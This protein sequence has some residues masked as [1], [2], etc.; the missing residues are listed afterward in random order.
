MIMLD[1]KGRRGNG[2]RRERRLMPC[3]S[4]YNKNSPVFC[5]WFEFLPKVVMVAQRITPLGFVH[6]LLTVGIFVPAPVE[7]GKHGESWHM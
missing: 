5:V 2:T 4:S 3:I 1:G 6:L 7:T